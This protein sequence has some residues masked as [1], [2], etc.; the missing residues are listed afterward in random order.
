MTAP[1]E[2]ALEPGGANVDHDRD[3][4]REHRLDD[5]AH[6]R[7]ET[8]RRVHLDHHR[9]RLLALR[10]LHRV[11]E[12]LLRD[13]VDVVVEL[14]HDHARRVH[15]RCGNHEEERGD[16]RREKEAE[17]TPE[18]RVHDVFDCTSAPR[19]PRRVVRIS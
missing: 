5:L 18:G 10:A 4:E 6:R 12:V 9:R 11:L 3:L 15:G 16:E 1:A 2:S 19:E 7:A 13:G 8:A 14:D 17:R